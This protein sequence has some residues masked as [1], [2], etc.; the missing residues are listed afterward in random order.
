MQLI[1]M[2]RTLLL[3]IQL[4]LAQRKMQHYACVSIEC[5][6]WNM[7]IKLTT[8]CHTNTFFTVMENMESYITECDDE[9]SRTDVTFQDGKATVNLTSPGFVA[10]LGSKNDGY[11]LNYTT[12]LRSR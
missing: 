6:A 2:K 9:H 1:K 11:L 4:A 12:C 7:T 5:A 10:E 8:V 3:I